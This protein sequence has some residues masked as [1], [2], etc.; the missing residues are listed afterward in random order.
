MRVRRCAE[1]QHIVYIISESDLHFQSEFQSVISLLYDDSHR[2][3]ETLHTVLQ[4]I[5]PL[6]FNAGINIF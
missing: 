3:S 1:E 4:K 2:S 5:F 6:S